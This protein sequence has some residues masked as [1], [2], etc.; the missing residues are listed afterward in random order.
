[1]NT[2]TN[3]I[4]VW[5][6]FRSMELAVFITIAFFLQIIRHILATGRYTDKST[7]WFFS[8]SPKRRVNFDNQVGR[9]TNRDSSVMTNKGRFCNTCDYI[10]IIIFDIRSGFI[11]CGLIPYVV[12]VAWWERYSCGTLHKILLSW[13]TSL[14]ASLGLQCES[15]KIKITKYYCSMALGKQVPNYLYWGNETTETWKYK[16]RA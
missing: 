1:M 5:L 7:F 9:T 11:R 6:G 16:R 2:W 12:Y 8:S 14:L 4:K 10:N 15:F 13:N 3:V